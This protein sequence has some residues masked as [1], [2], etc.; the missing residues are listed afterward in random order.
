VFTAMDVSTVAQLNG[1]GFINSA[2]E[3]YSSK[4]LQWSVQNKLLAPN[5][6]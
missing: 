4:K 5:T 2:T 3:A 1:G 6:C